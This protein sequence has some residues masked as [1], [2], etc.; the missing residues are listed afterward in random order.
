MIYDSISKVLLKFSII[1]NFSFIIEIFTL[2]VYNN[3]WVTVYRV[4]DL[5][6]TKEWRWCI[7]TTHSRLMTWCSS[8]SSC[9]HFWHSSMWFVISKNRKTTP[10]LWLREGWFFY[11]FTRSTTLWRLPVFNISFGDDRCKVFLI[12]YENH[13]HL[14]CKVPVTF[15]PATLPTVLWFP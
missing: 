3:E 13:H 4:V 12:P 6:S 10:I 11:H 5:Y 1:V 14:N 8:A 2:S 9:L 15:P 7:W